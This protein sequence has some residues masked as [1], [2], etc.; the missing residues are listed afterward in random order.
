MRKKSIWVWGSV[1]L[2]II[3]TT[4]AVVI[5]GQQTKQAP[6]PSATQALQPTSAVELT[7]IM[8]KPMGKTPA[9]KQDEKIKWVDE[10]FIQALR[11]TVEKIA[12]K[13]VTFSKPYLDG[14]EIVIPWEDGNCSVELITSTS[15]IFRFT[16]PFNNWEK[17]KK[18]KAVSALRTVVG[19]ANIEI[20]QARI[21]RVSNLNELDNKKEIYYVAGQGFNVSWESDED[22]SPRVEVIYELE[23]ADQNAVHAAKQALEKEMGKKVELVGRAV[24]FKDSKNNIWAFASTQEQVVTVYAETYKIEK[25]TNGKRK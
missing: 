16:I 17:S 19:D 3:G 5:W 2:I 14:K 21:T 6:S 18:E 20:E 12:G 1:F 8:E 9:Q 7:S 25:I 13:S 15:G 24:R 23:D 10:A 4:M 22:K 11:P